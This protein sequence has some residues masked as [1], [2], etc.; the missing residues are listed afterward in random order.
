MGEGA[1][2]DLFIADLPESLCDVVVAEG[3]L[4]RTRPAYVQPLKKREIIGSI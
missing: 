3:F 4:L 1:N 2:V